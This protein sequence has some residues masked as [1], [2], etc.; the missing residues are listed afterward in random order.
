MLELS[1]NDIN[2]AEAEQK[3]IELNLMEEW[4]KAKNYK[5]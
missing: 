4:N 1:G 5:D 3:I 2:T